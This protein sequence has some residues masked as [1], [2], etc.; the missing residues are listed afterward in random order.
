MTI[1]AR[2]VSYRLAVA[3]AATAIVIVHAQEFPSQP[4]Y[5]YEVVS[6]RRAAPGE[7]NSGF[8]PGVQGGMKARNVTAMQV[9]SFAYA[10]QDYQFIGAPGW[11]Q[12]E[13]FEI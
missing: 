4:A 2:R 5:K 13:R 6:V 9:L 12:S 8:G 11:A 3:L 7:M 1:Q 10:A